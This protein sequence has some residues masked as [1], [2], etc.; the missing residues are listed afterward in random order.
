MDMG[1]IWLIL[2]ASI[3]PLSGQVNA[4]LNEWSTLIPGHD[5][6]MQIT[7]DIITPADGDAGA[8]ALGVYDFIIGTDPFNPIPPINP[9]PIPAVV[10]LFGTGLLGLIGIGRREKA[11]WKIYG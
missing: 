4:A 5:Y 3:L 7:L 11:V 2:A 6:L 10:W 9:I 1:K 8:N